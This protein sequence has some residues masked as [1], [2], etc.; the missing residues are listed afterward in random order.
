M[1]E[2]LGLF[3]KG[4]VVVA[5]NVVRPGAPEYREFVQGHPGLKSEGVQGLIQPGDLEDELE[6]SYVTE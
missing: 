4:T 5:D 1:C 3:S 6:I 2:E